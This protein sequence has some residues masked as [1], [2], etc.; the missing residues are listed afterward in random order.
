LGT[1]CMTHTPS[2]ARLR[3]AAAASMHYWQRFAR[4]ARG[5]RAPDPAGSPTQ[6][7][8]KAWIPRPGKRPVNSPAAMDAGTRRALSV[9]RG[10]GRP[11]ADPSS[12][13]GSF[14]SAMEPRG[15]SRSFHPVD[16]SAILPCAARQFR[17]KAPP[18]STLNFA[19]RAVPGAGL[20]FGGAETAPGI[21]GGTTP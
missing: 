1:F 16:K 7:Q 11:V 10:P 20:R 13:A 4:H 8:A 3:A 18:I 12:G 15:L 17:P 14:D 5:R 19:R 2:R 9:M 21:D 6:S